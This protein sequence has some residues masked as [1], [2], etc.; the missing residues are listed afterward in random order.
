MASVVSFQLHDNRML[1]PVMINGKGPFTFVFDTGG[2]RTNT[3]TPEAAKK[4]ELV[5]VEG[6]PVKGAGSNKAQSWKTKVDQY[7]VGNLVLKD[8]SFT[9]ID[10]NSI[11]KAFDFKNLDG[12]IGLDVLK[13][14]VAC[15]NFDKQVL[16]LNSGEIDCFD[17]KGVVLPFRLDGRT[18]AIAG[19][20]NGISGEIVIDTGDRSAFSIFQ[21]FSLE[22]K[23]EAKFVDKP[24]VITG[25]GLGGA[26]PAKMAVLDEIKL[27]NEVTLYRVLSRRPYTTGNYFATSAIAGTIGN[28]VLRRF[29][30][31]LDYNRYEITLI[32]NNHFSEPY[33]FIPPKLD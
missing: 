14:A 28:E 17:T 15:I 3:I 27:G 8:Q 10:L 26:I 30:I 2:A 9:V 16:N 1:I 33:I 23:I 31:I 5:L 7:S 20:V 13:K 18:P 12:I 24:L 29:N 19:S 6:N 21:K 25:V 22:S 32:K 11:K 4:L